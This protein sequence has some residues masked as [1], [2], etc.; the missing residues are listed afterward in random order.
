MSNISLN[1]VEGAKWVTHRNCAGSHSCYL[2]CSIADLEMP[3]R[4][5]RD[6]QPK[7]RMTTS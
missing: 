7:M 5:L 2:M 6:L 3:A 1:Q 4:G